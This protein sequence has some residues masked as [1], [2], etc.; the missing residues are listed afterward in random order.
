MVGALYRL[1]YTAQQ[2]AAAQSYRLRPQQRASAEDLDAV[3]RHAHR[4]LIVI[5]GLIGD[6][7]MCLPVIGAARAIWPEATLT[8]LGQRH[9]CELT[10][11][12]AELDE[13]IETFLP[14]SIRHRHALRQVGR[15]LASR[16]FDVALLVLGDQFG[17]MVADA[18]IPV[19]VGVAGHTLAPC[20]THE[21]EIGSPRTWGP[22]E[23]LNALRVLGFS[24]PASRP[25]LRASTD[26]IEKGTAALRR[27]GLAGTAR[28]AVAHPFGS[29]RRQWW[30]IDRVC[31]V[32][33]YLA[34]EHGLRTVLIGGAE[35]QSE[36]GRA[37]GAD[38]IDATGQLT[39]RELIGVLAGASLV[40]STDSGPYH[41]AGALGR[42]L[43]GA[44]RARR[45]EH[46]DQYPQARVVFGEHPAC[47][48]ECAWDR[49]AS[50][51]CRQMEHIAAASVAAAIDLVAAGR[52]PACA[53]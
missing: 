38:V 28:Y 47:A 11:D 42:P 19:R 2:W 26:T 40:I 7:V 4:V 6:S 45:P 29:T 43:V 20:L 35:T 34:R 21:Y 52:Q 25:H 32:Q 23:R 3:A 27:L 10:M 24:V 33:Q 41:L 31:D 13:R 50:P 49:C 1:Q 53:P 15:E 46:A 14:F 48:T 9:N 16:R 37:A 51:T 8:L 36:A 22:N 5:A 44:F 12:C 30:P 17:R 39:I 18:R